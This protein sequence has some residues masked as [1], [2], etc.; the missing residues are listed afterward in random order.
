[1]RFFKFAASAW[2]VLQNAT[3]VLFRALGLHVFVSAF[4]YLRHLAVGKGYDE[5]TKIAIR[6]SRTIALMRA[7]IHIV[8][9]GVAMWEIIINWHFPPLQG[10]IRKY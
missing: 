2:L 1:M 5:P 10:L 4:R 6:K 9:I 3:T 8:P 7:L